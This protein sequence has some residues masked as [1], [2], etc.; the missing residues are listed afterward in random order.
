MNEI[1]RKT[2]RS[3]HIDNSRAEIEMRKSQKQRY[4]RDKHKQGIVTIER[5]KLEMQNRRQSILNKEQQDTSQQIQAEIETGAML[6]YIMQPQI[7]TEYI[8]IDKT[9]DTVT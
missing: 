3:K 5:G 8:Q 2:G 1:Y 4:T 6:V 7:P 9:D